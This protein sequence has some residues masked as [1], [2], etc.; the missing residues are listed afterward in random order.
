MRPV[1]FIGG[2]SSLYYR[3]LGIWN[4]DD[5]SDIML[6]NT[7]GVFPFRYYGNWRRRGGDPVG[8]RQWGLWKM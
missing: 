1:T 6:N 2:K 3:Q 7:L 8:I 4:L 5:T